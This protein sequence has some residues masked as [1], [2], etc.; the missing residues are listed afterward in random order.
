MTPKVVTGKT[1]GKKT[2]FREARCGTP[3]TATSSSGPGSSAGWTRSRTAR[4][5]PL[6][7]AGLITR[8]AGAAD[9]RR[10]HVA[11]TPAG[12]AAFERQALAGLLRTLVVTIEGERGRA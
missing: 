3:S 12:Y 8:T 2:T 6:E 9:R 1:I 10:V 5:Q 7:E 11:L 4:L